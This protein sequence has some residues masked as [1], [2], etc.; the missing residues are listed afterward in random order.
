MRYRLGFI[1]LPFSALLAQEADSG[2]DLRATITGQGVYDRTLT[3]SP[4]DGSPFVAG[5]RSLL[6]PTWKIWDHWA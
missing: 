1:F 2:I 3:Q 4:R 6:Y 5:F